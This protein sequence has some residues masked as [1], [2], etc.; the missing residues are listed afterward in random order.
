MGVLLEG[1]CFAS[2]WV[3]GKCQDGGTEG[4]FFQGRE[5][6]VVSLDD[7]AEGGGKVFGGELECKSTAFSESSVDFKQSRYLRYSQM[8]S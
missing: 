5:R 6:R 7:C 2:A 4:D 1:W 3:E 8:V